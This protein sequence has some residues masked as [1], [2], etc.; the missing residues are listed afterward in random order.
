[1]AI[2]SSLGIG[3]IGRELL[4]WKFKTK[5]KYKMFAKSHNSSERIYEEWKYNLELEKAKNKNDALNRAVEELNLNSTNTYEKDCNVVTKG[6]NEEIEKL[7]S[8]LE[9]QYKRLNVLTSQRKIHECTNFLKKE[10][11]VEKIASGVMIGGIFTLMY[12]CMPIIAIRDLL[13]SNYVSA[14]MA[15]TFILGITSTIVFKIKSDNDIKKAFNSLNRE[16]GED[17][18]TDEM[19]NT[20]SQ[21]Q[22]NTEIEHTIADFS[23]IILRNLNFLQ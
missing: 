10:S 8:N 14:Y 12:G 21:A 3:T 4:Q 1:M 19:I 2:I 17:A 15:T 9:E 20:Y 7:K 16:L 11:L 6:C 22:F 5:K 18:L 13:S 23:K